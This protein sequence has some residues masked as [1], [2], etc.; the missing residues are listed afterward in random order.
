MK[1]PQHHLRGRWAEDLAHTYLC[2][3][4]L[5]LVERNYRC[6]MGEIDLIMQH[7]DTLVFIEVRYR[8]NTRYG[9]SAES[10]DIHKQ[11]R[12]INTAS[13]YLYLHQSM[14]TC[15]CRFDVVLIEGHL[16]KPHLEWIADAFRS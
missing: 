6:K 8:A 7:H 2:Q 9:G 1:K 13:H 5:Q 12:L 4:G 11:H 15:S 3:Q 16:E 14:Q 10:I